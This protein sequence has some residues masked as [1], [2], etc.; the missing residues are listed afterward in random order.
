MPLAAQGRPSEVAESGGAEGCRGCQHPHTD[1]AGQARPGGGAVI[2]AEGSSPLALP[3]PGQHAGWLRAK[4]RQLARL[5]GGFPQ[6]GDLEPET[7]RRQEEAGRTVEWVRYRSEPQDAVPAVLMV[8]RQRTPPMPA[9]ICHHQHAG[10]W[11]LG[12]SE[13][14]GWA[15]D[16]EQ[17]YA[18]ELCRRGYAVLAPDVVGFE[19]RRHPRLGG[20]EYERFLAHELLLAGWTLQGKLIWDVMRAVDYLCGRPEV[21]PE[22]IGMMGHSMG[23][24]ETWFSMALEPRI[25]AGVV[26]CG[27]TTYAA[28]L[29]AEVIHNHGFYVPG[30]LKWGDIPEVVSLVAPRPLL[31]LAGERDPIFPVSGTR[32]VAARAG[33]LYRRLGVGEAL[34]L[35]VSPGAHEL[36]EEMRS[37]A[38]HWFDRWL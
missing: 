5:L 10:Q 3:S 7:L 4:R 20:A 17:A 16:R 33:V 11:E 32:E 22:R 12:K 21:D 15:G 25:K 2:W 19:E 8:P 37:R 1:R 36:T 38:Y 30:I 26:S 9:V 31:L 27:A 18:A 6:K 23:G 14:L 35:Y 29:A 13:V 34:E 24:I 28:V